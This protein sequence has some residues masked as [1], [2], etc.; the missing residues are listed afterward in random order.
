[1]FANNFRMDNCLLWRNYIIKYVGMHTIP[2]LPLQLPALATF[3]LQVRISLHS[4]VVSYVTYTLS[5]C[6]QLLTSTHGS[7]ATPAS[8][9]L[10]GPSVTIS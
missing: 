1:M 6:K 4:Y 5:V 7:T 10:T 3:P 8:I 2:T 9:T